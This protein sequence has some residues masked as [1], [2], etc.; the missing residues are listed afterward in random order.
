[1]DLADRRRAVQEN[2]YLITTHAMRRI[3]YRKV[4]H[5]DIKRVIAKGDVIEQHLDNVPDPKLLLMA[6][7]RDEPLYVSCAFDGR[8]AYI[9]T[10]HWY[11]PARWIDPWTRR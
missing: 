7:I 10:V 4:S 8:Y 5:D 9:V 11:D 1:V 2:R 6:H 3:G